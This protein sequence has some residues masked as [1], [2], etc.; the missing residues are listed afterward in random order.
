MSHLL[1]RAAQN[2]KLESLVSGHPLTRG[3]VSRFVAGVT[4]DEAIRVA[5]QMQREG[6]DVSLDLLGE[7]VEDLAESARATDQYIATVHAI[8]EQAPGTTVSVKLSQLGIAVDPET[9]AKN[10]DHLLEAAEEVGVLVEVDMEHSS[11]GRLTLETFREALPRHPHTRVAIQAALRRTPEDLDSFTDIKPR[12]RLVKGAYDEPLTRALRD[13]KEVTAQYQHLTDWVLAH[14]P[15]PAF[16]THDDACIEHAKK[17]AAAAGVGK[18]DFEFQMLYGVRRD[19]QRQL[20]REGYRVRVY[21][22]FGTQ[23]Y[24]YLMRRMAERPANLLF[25]LRSVVG[26]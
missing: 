9:C 14:C 11:V 26:R 21:V 19:V 5:K 15:D 22:P 10:L 1:L 13:R 8:A 3:L 23:W 16:G 6:I 25:F 4:C 18:E 2:K 7:Q 24:P 20:V 12:P 17:A